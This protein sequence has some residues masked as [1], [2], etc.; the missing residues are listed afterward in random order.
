MN[1]RD[2]ITASELGEYIFCKRGWQLQQTQQHSADKRKSQG[3]TTD[4]KFIATQTFRIRM[5]AAWLYIVSGAAI[6]V[7]IIFFS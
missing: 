7:Y 4:N 5:I 3:E 2:S 6:M 1:G